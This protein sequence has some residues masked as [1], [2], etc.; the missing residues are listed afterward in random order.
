MVRV[1]S[2]RHVKKLGLRR[3]VLAP[4]AR[5]RSRFTDRVT[6][7]AKGR[8]DYPEGLRMRAQL[9]TEVIHGGYAIF[10]CSFLHY[11]YCHA[12]LFNHFIAIM[13]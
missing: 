7:H 2:T 6:G 1:S 12:F 13:L 11:N 9:E 8:S 5:G 3:L 10:A 4:V